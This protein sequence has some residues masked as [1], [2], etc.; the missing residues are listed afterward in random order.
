MFF[1]LSMRVASSGTKSITS[2]SALF[3]LTSYLYLSLWLFFAGS[4]LTL[5][6]TSPYSRSYSKPVSCVK[7]MIS[8]LFNW[9]RSNSRQL[10]QVWIVE[11]C[12]RMVRETA[13]DGKHFSSWICCPVWRG[14]CETIV[15]ASIHGR[16]L[17]PGI[18]Q[19]LTILAQVQV[20]QTCEPVRRG[21]YGSDAR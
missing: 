17:Y 18:V 19:P 16:D 8:Y 6:S 12:R 9:V 1:V 13:G 10:L 5:F 21:N 2:S 4:F 11:R 3:V 7:Q 20:I 15:S 14:E